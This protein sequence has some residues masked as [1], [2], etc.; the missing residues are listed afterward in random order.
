[1]YTKS[2]S[3]IRNHPFNLNKGCYVF[4]DSMLFFLFA[5][6]QKFVS[7][8]FVNFSRHY[9][10]S[11][12]S[13]FKDTKCLHDIFSAHVRDIIVF[14]SLLTEDFIP[15]K[16]VAQPSPSQPPPPLTDQIDGHLGKYRY[17]I[18]L[19]FIVN[20]WFLKVFINY[21]HDYK[22][23]ICIEPWVASPT[24]RPEYILKWLFK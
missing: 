17:Q 24:V 4:P 18:N 8:Q 22:Q 2:Q 1:M 12:K 6:Q 23:R 21:A 7:G 11:T 16:L 20:T 10:L 19:S 5:A 3:V 14:P 15:N 9:F 13:F